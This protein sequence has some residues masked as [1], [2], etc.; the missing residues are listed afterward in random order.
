MN[1]ITVMRAYGVLRAGAV[2]HS[3]LGGLQPLSL[4]TIAVNCV[5]VLRLTLS[6]R[7]GA[8]VTHNG[9][10]GYPAT[11]TPIGRLASFCAIPPIIA[12]FSLHGM[13]PNQELARIGIFGTA[14]GWRGE[15]CRFQ[16]GYE[17]FEY[18]N[19]CLARLSY[20]PSPGHFQ[21]AYAH[22]A[23]K[24]RQETPPEKRRKPPRRASVTLPGSAPTHEN[25]AARADT[26]HVRHIRHVSTS[27]LRECSLALPCPD[28]QD[29]PIDS[30]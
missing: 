24:Y 8:L 27:A 11:A 17:S 6:K 25:D 2:H 18:E 22:A 13:A 21:R 12:N 1:Y 26:R 19:R 3:R 4:A 5:A 29:E 30:A 14:W 9:Q 7:A 16:P 28:L 23:E 10:F 20:R 15:S